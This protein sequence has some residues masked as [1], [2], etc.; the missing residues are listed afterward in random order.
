MGKHIQAPIARND[1]PL[2]PLLG[3]AFQIELLFCP[4]SGFDKIQMVVPWIPIGT[5]ISEQVALIEKSKTGDFVKR[6]LSSCKLART[7]RGLSDY[8]DESTAIED[9]T[10]DV[11]SGR[12][13]G[14]CIEGN[15]LKR[16]MLAGKSCR[17][18]EHVRFN[19]DWQSSLATVRFQPEA[20]SQSAE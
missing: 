9:D 7:G 3:Y 14:R 11:R 6:V 10:C 15:N 8:N 16:H 5:P 19:S 13:L 4:S 18:L 2:A 17:A 1:K 20:D 12:H